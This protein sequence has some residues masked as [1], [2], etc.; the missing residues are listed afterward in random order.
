MDIQPV[1][2]VDN[3]NAQKTRVLRIAILVIVVLALLATA[4][5]FAFP[6]IQERQV[7]QEGEKR[8]AILEELSNRNTNAQEL[9]FEER[10]QIL[11]RV[12]GG[13]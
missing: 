12:S 10:Q 4:V 13:E 7:I 6:M 11:E 3:T 2:P 9:T 5:W 8:R 1:A